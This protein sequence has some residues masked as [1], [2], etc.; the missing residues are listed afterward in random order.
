MRHYYGLVKPGI[1]YGNALPFVGAFFLATRGQGHWEETFVLALIGLSLVVASACVFNNIVDREGDAK[2]ERTKRRALATGD[3]S[4]GAAAVYGALLG[5]GGFALL[6]IY[7][8]LLAVLA[9]AVGFL[10]YV[11]AYSL[12]AKR[13]TPWATLVGS[14]AGA[15]PPLVGY[16]AGGGTD[17]RVAAVLFAIL[18]A[19][20][21]THFYAIAI[22]R[23]DEYQAAGIP[24]L[25]L[26]RGVGATKQQMV[27]WAL[28]FLL[29]APVPAFFIGPFGAG[30]FLVSLV[31]GF[32]W[33]LWSIAGLPLDDAGKATRAWARFMLLYSIAATAVL[34]LSM[35]AAASL[36]RPA[37]LLP[38][39]ENGAVTTQTSQAPSVTY[40]CD[41]G[42]TINATFIEG[43]TPPPP[44]PGQPP[45]MTGNVNL[46][47]GDGTRMSLPR[48]LSADGLRYANA[49][50]SF[51]F[52]SKGQ[53]AMVLQNGAEKDFTNC[54][55]TP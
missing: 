12:W 45:V 14:V 23:A 48:T 6:A 17:P 3:V 54:V 31:L 52:W 1:V 2:M 4:I 27:F 9:A 16:A 22:R 24:V 5:A 28:V 11:F 30:Y 21:M 41:G 25:P 43:A 42:K 37:M 19:W 29:A 39:E 51:V 33:L 34:F 36:N 40:A 26:A 46:V 55:E 35:T 8:H 53:T 49:D 7:G 38:V 44:Q 18:V 15:M 50:E 32:V 20:Q 47:F 10:V 13:R